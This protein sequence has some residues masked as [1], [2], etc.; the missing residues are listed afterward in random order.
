MNIEELR[1]ECEAMV[2]AV[3]ERTLPEELTGALVTAEAQSLAQMITRE[4]FEPHGRLER[5]RSVK[6]PVQA[7]ARVSTAGFQ[8]QG[9]SSAIRFAG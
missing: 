8:F 3:V 9:R 1:S 6:G 2:A 5:K 4:V 7:A